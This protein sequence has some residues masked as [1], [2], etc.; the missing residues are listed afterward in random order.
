MEKQK[1]RYGEKTAPV[2]VSLSEEAR[3]RLN[4]LARKKGLR[5]SIVIEE[6]LTY[7]EAH[8]L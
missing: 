1:R 4:Y 5:K 3:N 8:V 7:Y 2:S 6:A